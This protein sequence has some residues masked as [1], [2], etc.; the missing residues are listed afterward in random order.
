MSFFGQLKQAS[1]R[2]ISFG[3]L[4]A[5]GSFGRRNSIHEYPF[6]DIVFVEDLGR[7]ARRIN[8]VG[9]LLENDAVYQGT[10]VITQRENLIAAVETPGGGEL[11]HPTLGRLNVALLS[12][13]VSERWDKGRYFEIGFS[14]IEAGDRLFPSTGV[15]TGDAV[16]TAAIN[17]D[18][19]ST[20]DF[21][22]RAIA[23]LQFGAAIV[24]QAVSTATA[25]IRLANRLA[26]DA[27][28]LHSL[29]ALLPGNFGR[30]FGGR[31]SGGLTGSSVVLA[32][33][34][35]TISSLISQGTVSRANVG[36][37]A[38]T[39]A[40]TAAGLGSPSD[41]SGLATAAQALAQ[42]VLEATVDPADALRLL[43][44]LA[45]FTP[46]DINTTSLIGLAM[47]DMQN[48]VGNVFRRAALSQLA[49]AASTYQ[50]SSYDDAVYVRTLVC[51]LLDAEIAL[52]GDAGEDDSF[53]ALRA[54]RNAVVQDL[55]AR[56]ATL[57]P[58]ITFRVGT[59]LPSQVLAL[60]LYKDT[61]RADELEIQ[62]NPVHPL[63]CAA[64]FRALAR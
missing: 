36:A 4:S 40:A 58:I 47:A 45:T 31:T 27:T 5:D 21:L 44:S 50:P 10:D 48:T 52:A 57:A 56:G 25:L 54:L 59:N 38:T 30:Y 24:T 13:S 42:A 49:I 51:G 32:G 60:R 3:V 9:F 23:D 62:I 17:L 55:T 43:A 19:M 53:A 29:V 22:T 2:N 12:M 37:Q 6:R 7:Q 33:T 18:A 39:L 14:F 8:I 63:F 41:P 34:P 61:G 64:T 11:I 46:S 15:S 35:P 16:T 20:A 28:N 1:Y 26:N